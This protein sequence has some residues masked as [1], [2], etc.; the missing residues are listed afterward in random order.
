MQRFF[1]CCLRWVLKVYFL[2]KIIFVLKIYLSLYLFRLNFCLLKDC[3]LLV[4]FVP[5]LLIQNQ[6]PGMLAWNELLSRHMKVYMTKFFF[7][8]LSIFVFF[9]LVVFVCGIASDAKLRFASLCLHAFDEFNKF[10]FPTTN[11]LAQKNGNDF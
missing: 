3:R 1:H 10:C 2:Y 6:V 5:L 4:N 8:K 9:G 11:V 7:Q